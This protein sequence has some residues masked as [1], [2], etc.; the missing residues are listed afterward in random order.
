MPYRESCL[1]LMLKNHLGGSS[2]T[3]M[4]A[5]VEPSF[6]NAQEV[7]RGTGFGKG[8]EREEGN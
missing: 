2:R 8:G 1:T 7:G 5:C 3:L 4:I 6:V